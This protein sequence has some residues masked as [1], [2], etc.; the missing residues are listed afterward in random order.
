MASGEVS[1]I[2]SVP[3]ELKDIDE[4]IYKDFQSVKTGRVYQDELVKHSAVQQTLQQ[5]YGTNFW[6]NSP[7]PTCFL[8]VAVSTCENLTLVTSGRPLT[9]CKKIVKEC[10]LTTN[11]ISL[12]EFAVLC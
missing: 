4:I 6:G 1:I 5:K 12:A 7:R 10:A 2:K 11:V 8:L 3:K 9:D